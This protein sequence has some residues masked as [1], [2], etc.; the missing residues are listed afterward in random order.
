[1]GSGKSKVRKLN[2]S[3]ISELQKNIDVDFTRDEIEEWFREYQAT[4]RKGQSRLTMREFGEVYSSVFD[5]DAN[6]FVRHLFRSFDMDNDGFVDFK[7]FIVGLCVSGSDKPE[8]K[9]KW[10]F[11]MYDIDGN[12]SISREEMSSMLKAIYRMIST[13]MSNTKAD[14][15]TIEEL[16][17]EFFRS[18]DRNHDDAISQEEFMAGV[19]EM[20]AIL[21]LLQC[22]PAAEGDLQ[23][24]VTQLDSLDIDKE[25]LPN[26]STQSKTSGAKMNAYKAS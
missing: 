23:G 6:G 9:L 5:G 25:S 4:L 19:R 12:G 24:P 18:A 7:E 15:Q 20:P 14:I 2:P 26:A 1:M 17:V 13:D 10:A 11:K 3:T 16:V 8:V 22:D 21:H